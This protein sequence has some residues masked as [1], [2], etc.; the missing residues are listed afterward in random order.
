MKQFFSCKMIPAKLKLFKQCNV[1]HW[2]DLKQIQQQSPEADVIK[3][4]ALSKIKITVYNNIR[5]L[6]FTS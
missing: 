3:L 6:E 2:T 4:F 1:S 5:L